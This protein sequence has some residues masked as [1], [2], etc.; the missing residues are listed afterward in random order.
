L[1][2]VAAAPDALRA[3]VA[4]VAAHLSRWHFDQDAPLLG[5]ARC[6]IRDAGNSADQ[7]GTSCSRPAR[8]RSL[9]WRRAT[10]I[11]A[12]INGIA[13]RAQ[14]VGFDTVNLVPARDVNG[15]ATFTAAH[16]VCVALGQISRRI[17]RAGR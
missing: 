16:L 5:L 14:L 13:A 9:P 12:L 17:E 3:S 11:V 2:H 8:C 4:R 1:S 15:I 10:A 7:S 6:R